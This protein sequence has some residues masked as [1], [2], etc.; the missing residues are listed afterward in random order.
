VQG[1]GG[2]DRKD[3]EVLALVDVRGGDVGYAGCRG[4]GIPRAGGVQWGA[5]AGRDGD[6]DAR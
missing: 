2:T 4:H 6:S 5:D 1:D 3:E